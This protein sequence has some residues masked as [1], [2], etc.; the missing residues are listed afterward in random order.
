MSPALNAEEILEV[1]VHIE[2][3]G[4]A[5]YRRAA[6]LVEDP[7][8]KEMLT[9]LAK[10]EDSH[11]L[12]FENMRA[13]PG[14]LSQL[15]GDPNGEAASYLHAFADDQV[16][17]A[18][19]DPQIQSGISLQDVL[20]HAISMELKSIAFYHGIQSAMRSDAQN[21]KI[22][23]IIREER[24]HVTILSQHLVSVLAQSSR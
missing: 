16:F 7:A 4:S 15:I 5:Y 21:Q 8:A 20:R 9:G 11:E 2:R 17:P 18:A 14:I 3:T 24:Q 10:M 23:D 6:K 19:P 13:D 12:L 1:A 22:A